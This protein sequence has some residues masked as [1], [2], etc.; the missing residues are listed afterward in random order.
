MSFKKDISTAT[1]AKNLYDFNLIPD[2]LPW[3]RDLTKADKRL[4][5]IIRR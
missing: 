3:Q 1:L 4:I 2:G 5:T